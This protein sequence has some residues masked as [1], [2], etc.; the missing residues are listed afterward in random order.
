MIVDAHLHLWDELKGKKGT[1]DVYSLGGGK[2]YF[3]DEVK[4]M[5]PP[6]MLDG[7]N[8]V[9]M[10]I[11]NM[12][13]ARVHAAV[14]TQEYIDGNQDAYLLEAKA[15]Y[16]DRI[17]ICSLYQ[18]HDDYQLEGFDGIKICAGR[19]T[20]PLVDTLP[21]FKK[22]E[23]LGKFVSIDLSDGDADVAAMKEII[24]ACPNLRIAI[25]HF[26]MVTVEG[27]EEQIALA[28]NPNVYIESGGITWLFHGEYYPYPSAVDAIL[29]AKEI[30]GIEK[31]MWGSDY[32]RT[33]TAITYLMSLDFVQKSDKMTDEDKALFLGETAKKFYGIETNVELP[34]I[35]NMVE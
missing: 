23:A 10:L 9:E 17:K 13:Y 11:A 26:G 29:R 34:Y 20:M 8:T 32:P 4:Q 6:Y 2:S 1:L 21:V 31:L 27:W 30:C 35:Y 14:V 3:G 19:L 22:A 28:K 25:G 16:P 5:M 7:R 33:M 18:E 24:A 12:D 15:K